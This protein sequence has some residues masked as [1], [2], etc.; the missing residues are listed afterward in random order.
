MEDATNSAL[1]ASSPPQPVLGDTD[2]AGPSD[3]PHALAIADSNTAVDAREPK[4]SKRK[5]TAMSTESP[6]LDTAVGG[7]EPMPVVTP[8]RKPASKKSKAAAACQEA[9]ATPAEAV[10]AAVDAVA[11]DDGMKAKKKVKRQKVKASEVAVDT[12]VE[13]LD[14]PV[15]GSSFL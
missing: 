8:K 6:V 3:A 11:S 5:C 13:L 7:G 4:T 9:D 1:A 2:S 12:E 14:T 10:A 15:N